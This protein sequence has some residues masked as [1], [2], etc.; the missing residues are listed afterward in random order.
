MQRRKLTF[1]H[2]SRQKT[3]IK[4]RMLGRRRELLRSLRETSGHWLGEAT[5]TPQNRILGKLKLNCSLQCSRSTVNV[6]ILFFV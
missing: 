5:A 4:K 6:I 3:A 1:Q 2:M